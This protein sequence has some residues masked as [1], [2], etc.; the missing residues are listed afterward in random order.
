MSQP[1]TVYRWDDAGAPQ[2]PNGKP[3][4]II[5][6][7]TKCLV[8]GYGA[9]APLGWTRPYY[10]AAVQ[11]AVFRNNVAGGGSGG[12]AKFYSNDASDSNNAVMRVT[13]AVSMTGLNDFFRQGYTQA[14][15]AAVGT[16]VNKM[17]KWVLI[18]TAI[19]FYFFISRN[20]L[21]MNSS[22]SYNATMY[23][24]D[25]YSCIAGDT[26]KFIS[27]VT[28]LISDFADGSQASYTLDGLGST[29]GTTTACLKIYH[30]D[31]FEG[32][33]SYSLRPIG[34]EAGL[35]TTSA[36]FNAIPATE[37]LLLPVLIWYTNGAINSTTKDRL[38]VLINDSVIS[39]LV[40]GVLPGI[41][42]S[43][44]MG[45]RGASWPQTKTIGGVNHWVMRSTTGSG[46]AC[47]GFI[48]TEVWNDPFGYV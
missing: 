35:T 3:S 25:F 19:G 44:K 12:Y 29:G 30:A 10:D 33:N 43:L 21:P 17:D 9:K 5:D 8:D 36:D 4:E 45:Y 7:L 40:R 46:S 31:N 11:A 20:T 47:S 38:N 34:I 23:V 6:V 15:S 2:I 13:H 28:H 14:F 16:G 42:Y 27:I 32:F 39:P 41:N 24:G 1:V 37:H 26:S 48:N 18:G 22:T